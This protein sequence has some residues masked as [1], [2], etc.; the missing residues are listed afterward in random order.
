MI[1]LKNRNIIVILII[2][3]I[4]SNMAFFAMGFNY[5][6]TGDDGVVPI[7]QVE[8]DA[9]LTHEEFL[10]KL[11]RIFTVVDQ[12]YFNEYDW[13]EIY[14]QVY[15]DLIS[16]LGDQYSEYL[17]P[18]DIEDLYIRSG[19]SYGG[20]GV[21][22]SMSNG[23]VTVVTPMEGGP[24]QKAGLLPGDAI[25]EVDGEN[26]E[27]LTLSETV[28]LIRGE[29]D[30]EVVLGIY[31]EGRRDIIRV[32]IVRGVITTT[33]V[34]HK[35]IEEDLGYIRLSRFTE[36]S[37]KDFENALNDLKS[38]GLDSLIVDLR[39]NPGGYL[40]VVVNI[41]N[42]LVPEGEV[43]YMENKHGERTR[44]YVSELKERDFEVVVLIDEYSASASEILAGALKDSESAILVGKTTFGKGSVQSL[45][46][47]NDG[48]AVKLTFQKYFTPSGVVID[49]V[50]V[51]PHIEVDQPEFV[52]FSNLAY[53]G[54]LE[55]GSTGIDVI[56]LHR[57]LYF[58]GY[59]EDTEDSLFTDSTR[60]AVMKFQRSNGLN[61]TGEVD[62]KTADA[63]NQRFS[64]LQRENDEQLKK[65]I[66]II[67]EGNGN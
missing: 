53:K 49:G 51:S 57:I 24:G 6:N 50:G 39:G 55:V 10:S 7:E 5:A 46:D 54:K 32:P 23:R 17:S 26:V 11:D 42:M 9:P 64:K 3:F 28:D 47:L 31:R 33:S 60:D 18:R 13:E 19:R 34:S 8:Q 58:L 37:D 29:P 63:I 62:M 22:V 56:I 59:G 30:T 4:F 45:F 12:Y 25:I 65:A 43:V 16:A 61:V 27:G 48:S 1:V 36:G 21:E 52:N 15:R 67:R 35:F 44:T 41:A 14:E 40:D 2:T 20:I 66:E 38:Q